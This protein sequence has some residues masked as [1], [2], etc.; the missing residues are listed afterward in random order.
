MVVFWITTTIGEDSPPGGTCTFLF[1]GRSYQVV[2]L[3][4]NPPCSSICLPRSTGPSGKA[5][6]KNSLNDCTA[7][8]QVPASWMHSP[9]NGAVANSG[10]LK[11]S[12]TRW[13]LEFCALWEVDK[14]YTV[15]IL[16]YA[17]ILYIYIYI[18]RFFPQDLQHTYP[19]HYHPSLSE[20]IWFKPPTEVCSLRNRIGWFQ[21]GVEKKIMSSVQLF[22]CVGP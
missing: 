12:L 13:W 19:T 8:F 6:T 3:S 22:F 20:P 18:S 21:I 17:Y 7:W 10:L 15:Y 2:L 14:M 11:G 9:P 4:K 1:A 16:I 5:P